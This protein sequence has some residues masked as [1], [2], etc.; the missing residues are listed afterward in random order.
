[1]TKDIRN[2][3]YGVSMTDGR[4]EQ[5]IRQRMLGLAQAAVNNGELR[6]QDV[7]RVEMAETL[8]EAEQILEN[9]WEAIMQRQ[10]QTK[11]KEIQG[12][13]QQTQQQMEMEQARHE[14][15][16]QHDKDIVIL[17]GE[18]DKEVKGME[19]ADKRLTEK[20]KILASRQPV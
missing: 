2:F 17:K 5:D 7:I 3:D 1:L 6:M 10:N 12:N 18:V 13:Q 8:A 11:E 4:K 16:Q 15:I 14:D 9:S 19:A 20:E